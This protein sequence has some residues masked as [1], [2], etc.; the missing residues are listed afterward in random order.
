MQGKEADEK[1]REIALQTSAEKGW[2][3]F[4]L[5]CLIADISLN[6]VL[7][8]MQSNQN[9]PGFDSVELQPT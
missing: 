8:K 3:T 6:F 4:D 1:I 7:V 2:D 9:I 5:L